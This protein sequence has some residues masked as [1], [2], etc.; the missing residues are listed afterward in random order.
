M[1]SDTTGQQAAEL[2]DLLARGALHGLPRITVGDT[3]TT[4]AELAV[5]VFLANLDRLGQTDGASPTRRGLIE[6]HIRRA[7]QA[8]TTAMAS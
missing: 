5:R 4:D 8:V 7:H 6:E 1:L 2:R 3:V